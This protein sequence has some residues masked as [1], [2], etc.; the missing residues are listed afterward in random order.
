M[1]GVH[2]KYVEAAMA[3]V[4]GANR[5]LLQTPIRDALLPV[6][7][8]G[9]GDTLDLDARTESS[10]REVLERFDRRA[11]LI[12]EEKSDKVVAW[13]SATVNGFRPP[14]IFVADPT[15]RSSPLKKYLMENEDSSLNVAMVV[16]T[17]DACQKW[18]AS[19]GGPAVITGACSAVTCLMD[20]QPLCS[21]IVNYITQHLFVACP[22]G[23]RMLKLREDM[24]ETN[25]SLERVLND[26]EMLY[27]PPIQNRNVDDMLRFTTF[28][29]KEG[30]LKNF[31]D[32]K[33]MDEQAMKRHLVY[34]LPGGPLRILY[35]SNLFSG[36]PPM[37]FILAN[38]EK[39]GEWVHW[40]AY[41]L[42]ATQRNAD[43]E[44]ALKLFE[45]FQEDPAM[46]NGILMAPSP[47]YSPLKLIPGSENVFM[48]DPVTL[49]C[50]GDPSK[51]RATLLVT[52]RRNQEVRRVMELHRF[53][54]I[55][56]QQVN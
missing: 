27:F 25:L 35:L 14:I 4:V 51:V 34:D 44:S 23:I 38:G 18:E 17:P 15:D 24:D 43:D 11:S 28:L 47:D 54:R 13:S 29:G 8:Y 1:Q 32:S 48:I 42:N 37:G 56:F 36:S 12:T 6:R 5:Y 26:G 52:P 45:I 19:F 31:L 39:F 49:S 53:R 3:A 22:A 21:A 55:L 20:G 33:L 10:I 2:V 9:K 50:F 16:G 30:Y 40:L 46:K 7:R 41:V